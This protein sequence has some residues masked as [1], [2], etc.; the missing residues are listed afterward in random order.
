MIIPPVSSG[1]GYNFPI[2]GSGSPTWQVDY[3]TC[4]QTCFASNPPPPTTV[5]LPPS[6]QQPMHDGCSGSS[7]GVSSQASTGQV[8][9]IMVAPVKG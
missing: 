8:W 6:D 2:Y 7:C 3:N 9:N 4:V 5:T 1:N